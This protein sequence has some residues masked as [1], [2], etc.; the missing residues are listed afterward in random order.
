MSN[1]LR[2]QWEIVK[3]I[4]RHPSRISTRELEA[5]LK[6]QGITVSM[7]TIQRD[8]HTLATIFSGL[9]SDGVKDEAGWFWTKDSEIHDFPTMNPPMA[10]AFHLMEALNVERFS[11]A[12]MQDVQPYFKRSNHIL[13]SLP[14]KNMR[15]YHDKFRIMPR[16]Q[17]LIPAEI[18]SKVISV[19]YE[20]LLDGKQFNGCYRRRDGKA[21]DYD[22]HPLGLVFRESVVYLV[23]TLW[24]YQEVRQLALHRFS[25]CTLLNR[26]ATVPADFRLDTYIQSGAFEYKQGDGKPLKLVALFAQ[27]AAYHLRETRLSEDQVIEETGD[28]EWVRVTASV[29]NTQQLRWWLL[30]FGAYVQVL[31]P[32]AL[33]EEFAGVSEE[34]RSLY[35]S[36]TTA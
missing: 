20:A 25:A 36:S 27:G 2:R 6:D 17:P 7:R 33:R 23:A 15:K 4:P 18:D 21:V 22:I 32:L 13:E 12:V 34:M 10:F 24:D 9:T 31:E 1:T 14:Q 5:H 8:L 19:I 26:P 28:D 30:G 16:S 3:R 35:E 11:P 29:L